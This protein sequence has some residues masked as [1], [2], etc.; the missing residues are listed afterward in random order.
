MP[1]VWVV[2]EV[3]SCLALVLVVGIMLE[4]DGLEMVVVQTVVVVGIDLCIVGKVSK[5][6]MWVVT[7]MRKNIDWIV[8]DCSIWHRFD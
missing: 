1:V 4:V 3:P 6:M 5:S 2:A 8:L 7:G